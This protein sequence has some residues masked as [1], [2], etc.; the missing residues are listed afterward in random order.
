MLINI[1]I[2][3]QRCQRL[4]ISLKIAG[5]LQFQKFL[6]IWIQLV[7][8]VLKHAKNLELKQLSDFPLVCRKENIHNLKISPKN[9]KLPKN[10]KY[11]LFCKNK[12][13]KITIN[14]IVAITK[15]HHFG[16]QNHS[17]NT[18]SSLWITNHTSNYTV[19]LVGSHITAVYNIFVCVLPFSKYFVSVLPIRFLLF[20][21]ICQQ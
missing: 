18:Y 16:E 9:E 13:Q 15:I 21:H 14:T 6:H 17:K 19:S 7:E 10:K 12:F 11:N 1:G 8:L 20:F 4:H 2:A 3:L 5:L